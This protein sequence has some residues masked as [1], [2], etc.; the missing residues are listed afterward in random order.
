MK[1]HHI[2]GKIEPQM[3]EQMQA[4]RNLWSSVL[5]YAVIDVSGK[6]CLSYG[7]LYEMVGQDIR[8]KSLTRMELHNLRGRAMNTMRY[9]ARH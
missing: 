3:D 6:P 4:L 2:D 1:T 5:M 9:H 8:K 7:E